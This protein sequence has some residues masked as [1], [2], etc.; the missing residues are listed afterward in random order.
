[1]QKL[2]TVQNGKSFLVH[3]IPNGKTGDGYWID[4]DGRKCRHCG[5]PIYRFRFNDKTD[6]LKCRNTY[7][8]L[9]NT[10]RG[11]VKR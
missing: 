4:P 10:Y 3:E 11:C 9:L 5:Q 6:G 7:C 2:T 8:F 1:M